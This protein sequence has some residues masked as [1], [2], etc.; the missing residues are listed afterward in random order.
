MINIKIL[1]PNKIKTDEKP[2]KNIL[3]YRT[4]Y[5]TVKE[6]NYAKINSL[7]PLYL[8]TGKINGFNEGSN[9]NKYLTLVSILLDQ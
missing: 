2:Y 5:V 1:D 7:Y 3:I 8:I 9:G 4:G 6:L